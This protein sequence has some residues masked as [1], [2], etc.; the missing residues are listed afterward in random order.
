MKI[1]FCVNSANIPGVSKCFIGGYI[2]G[3]SST[4]SACSFTDNIISLTT[5]SNIG[6]GGVHP[7]VN[8]DS[9]FEDVVELMILS[10][11][12]QA[13]TLLRRN[14][15]VPMSVPTFLFGQEV[16]KYGRNYLTNWLGW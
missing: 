3:T 9:I 8:A 14:G 11:N 13:D 10:V 16:G 4:V 2:T 12:E 15:T 6:S 5:S 7:S 1:T